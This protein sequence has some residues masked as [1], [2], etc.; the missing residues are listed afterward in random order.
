MKKALKWSAAIIV[1]LL[2]PL[3]LAVSGLLVG[4]LLQIKVI[5]LAWMIHQR[6]TDNGNKSDG[7]N[8]G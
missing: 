2:L 7:A 8:K 6:E 1:F 5:W 3:I 4:V